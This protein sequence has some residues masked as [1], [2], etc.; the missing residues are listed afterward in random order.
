MSYVIIRGGLVQETSTS[1][2]TV[3]DCDVLDGDGL[4]IPDLRASTIREVMDLRHRALGEGI[5]W[6]VNECDE[7][8][9]SNTT[10]D[11]RGEPA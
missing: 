10:A 9:D 8:L 6:L 4:D 1:D 7:F 2:I 11:E 5:E 3:L